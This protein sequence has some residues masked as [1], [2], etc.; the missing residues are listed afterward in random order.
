MKITQMMGPTPLNE[1]EWAQ[2]TALEVVRL[3]VKISGTAAL[4]FRSS[5]CG[6]FCL[7]LPCPPQ[8]AETVIKNYIYGLER[9]FNS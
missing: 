3:P 6:L 7:L 4:R 5:I 2:E 1:G 9:W 8:A